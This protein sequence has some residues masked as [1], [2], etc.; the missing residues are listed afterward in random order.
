MVEGRLQTANQF[1]KHGGN[2]TGKPPRNIQKMSKPYVYN[3]VTFKGT[4]FC[5]ICKKQFQ[6]VAN[7]KRHV[8]ATHNGV[9]YNCNQCDYSNKRQDSLKTHVDFVH[10]GI[11]YPCDQCDYQGVRNSKLAAHIKKMHTPPFLENQ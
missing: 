5:E 4:I 3:V 1:D 9:S 6:L 10:E 11:R 2:D 7:L 8:E